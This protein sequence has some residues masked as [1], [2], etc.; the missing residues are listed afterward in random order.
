[1]TARLVP[2]RI[3]GSW[4]VLHNSF[5]D[6]DPTI[7][8]GI[9]VNDASYNEDVLS[10]EHLCYGEQGWQTDPRGLVLDLGWYPEADPN[11]RYRLTVLRGDWDHVLLRLES[12][13][14]D[15]IRTAI[16]SCLSLATEGIDETELGHRVE[17][18]AFHDGRGVGVPTDHLA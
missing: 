17:A 2:L 13:D 4:A 7:H 3:P 11:G 18:I 9:I 12:R 5:L 6:E 8:D 10:I 16:D 15:V 1:M 14:R